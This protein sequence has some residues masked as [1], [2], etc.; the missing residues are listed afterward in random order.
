MMKSTRISLN[1]EIRQL[2]SSSSASPEAINFQRVIAK[3]QE[4]ISSLHQEILMLK[5]YITLHRTSVEPVCAESST[6]STNSSNDTLNK[7]LEESLS[8]GYKHLEKTIKEIVSLLELKEGTE[9]D[10]P[11]LLETLK[12]LKESAAKKQDPIFVERIKEIKVPI[13]VEKIIERPIEKIVEK[14]VY[15]DRPAYKERTGDR[16]RD[17]YPS[18]QYENE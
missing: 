14:I 12:Q 9:L 1:S 5:S 3:Q 6:I 13:T 7:E 8:N 17:R 18:R 16:D 11:R 4:V 15:V 2:A 10:D